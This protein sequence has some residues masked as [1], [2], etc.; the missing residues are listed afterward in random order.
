[1]QA[2]EIEELD[3]ILN[4]TL[5]TQQ[6]MRV[7]EDSSND[8]AQGLQRRLTLIACVKSLNDLADIKLNHP[9]E[10]RDMYDCVVAF[11]EHTKVL[12]HLARK[13]RNLMEIAHILNEKNSNTTAE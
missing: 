5:I 6:E 12:R 10:F 3:G 4:A 2:N 1:M 13:A 9:Q 11:H 7:I 8:K